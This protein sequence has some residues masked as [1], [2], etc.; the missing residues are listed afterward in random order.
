MGNSKAT[1]I[2]A[3]GRGGRKGFLRSLSTAISM[4]ALVVSVVAL[5]FSVVWRGQDKNVSA[6]SVMF[7][8][9]SFT[10]D[11][12]QAVHVAN[13]G[14]LPLNRLYVEVDNLER[15]TP[16]GY[17]NL[18][19]V[20]GLSTVCGELY[21]TT[22]RLYLPYLPSGETFEFSV[23]GSGSD[24]ATSVTNSAGLSLYFRDAWSEWWQQDLDGPPK[25]ISVRDEDKKFGPCL[26]VESAFSSVEQQDG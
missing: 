3:E 10:I 20:R 16:G 22:Y 17:A 18:E 5:T 9:D 21:G 13:G 15:N 24:G 14:E 1:G 8:A 12:V 23:E 11:G 2:K 26:Q 25:K 4:L 6:K 19:S 7:W